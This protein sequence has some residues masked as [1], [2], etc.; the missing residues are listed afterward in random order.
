MECFQG[1]PCED[2]LYA[3][4]GTR[5]TRCTTSTRRRRELGGDEDDV[6]NSE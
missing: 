5:S 2:K 4:L 6:A 3:L 1:Y